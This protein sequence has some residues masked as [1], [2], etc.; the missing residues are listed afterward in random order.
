MSAKEVRNNIGADILLA[1]AANEEF[2]IGDI[3][4]VA[5]LMQEYFVSEGFGDIL[6]ELEHK[7][8]P[9]PGY[10]VRHLCDVR[11]YLRNEKK[12]F[13]EYKR[14]RIDGTFKGEWAFVRK[15]E[16]QNVM[17]KEQSSLATRA[18]TYNKRLDE[19]RKKWKLDNPS[20][21]LALIGFDE[22]EDIAL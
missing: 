20:V 2:P 5:T 21:H 3:Y 9:D 16:F 18:E 8:R 13:L 11:E 10:W 6:I 7:W 15:G 19:A 22:K 12:I 14:E 1:M 4:Q 17:L